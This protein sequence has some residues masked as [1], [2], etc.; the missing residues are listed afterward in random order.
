MPHIFIVIALAS[1]VSGFFASHQIDKAKLQKMSFD[2]TTQNTLAEAT[3][4]ELAREADIANANAIKINVDLDKAH[5]EYIATANYYDQQLDSIRL[6]ADRR[7]CG[8]SAATASDPAGV[9]EDSTDKAE[10]AESLD[11]LVKR[12]A[13]QCD[14]AADYADK[15]YQFTTLNNCGITK[16]RDEHK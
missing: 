13:A 5:E 15:A 3:I 4:R 16:D 14:T 9:L 8:A 2:I 7:P 11:R 1:F 6:Y 10:Y 12:M